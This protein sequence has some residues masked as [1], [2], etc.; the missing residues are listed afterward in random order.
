[1]KKLLFASVVLSIFSISIVVFQMSCTKSA[2]AQSN[3]YVLP[4]ATTSTLGGVIIGSG[5]SVTSN[6]TLSTT[7]TAGLSQ[8]SKLLFVKMVINNTTVSGEI[9]TTNFDGANQTKVNIVL[10]SG[11]SISVG[12]ANGTDVRLSPDGKIIFFKTINST[13]GNDIYSCNID[14][15]NVQKIID[16]SSV[17]GLFLGGAY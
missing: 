16:G 11:V 15:S 17:G 14:G 6:G 5:L 10:P 2:T 8:L 1:M 9:W 12:S 13:S 3:N 4:P 7:S